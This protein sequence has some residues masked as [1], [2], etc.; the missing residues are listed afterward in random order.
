M[1]CVQALEVV[2]MIFTCS[3][4]ST[5]AASC[6]VL[7]K[8][9]LLQDAMNNLKRTWLSAQKSLNRFKANI[10][11]C[12]KHLHETHF[13]D[14]C[15]SSH[16]LDL[17]GIKHCWFV[18]PFFGFEFSIIGLVLRRFLWIEDIETAIPKRHCGLKA[19]ICHGDRL[20]ALWWFLRHAEMVCRCLQFQQGS[21]PG[22]LPKTKVLVD[23]ETVYHM[24]L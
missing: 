5:L 22:S 24:T 8:T 17:I 7:S 23:R 15:R 2:Y 6:I 16:C 3:K 10:R 4:P 18:S 19:G 1:E 14:G 21:E 12:G 11:L 13:Q 20:Q 9:I